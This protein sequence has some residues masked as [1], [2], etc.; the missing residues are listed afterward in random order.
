MGRLFASGTYCAGFFPF[1]PLFFLKVNFLQVRDHTR[2]ASV[3][4]WYS[5]SNPRTRCTHYICH[6]IIHICHIIIERECCLLVLL[7]KKNGATLSLCASGLLSRTFFSL[8]KKKQHVFFFQ[9]VFSYKKFPL[10]RLS[11]LFYFCS[12]AVLFLFISFLFSLVT[13]PQ[14]S[15][16]SRGGI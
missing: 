4:Y 7:E 9:N 8:S 1:F 10:P 3:V 13:A 5:L 16:E 11:F 6:I 12:I 15:N 2:R 14:P